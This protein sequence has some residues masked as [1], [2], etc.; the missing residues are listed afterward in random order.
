ML[1][2]KDFKWENCVTVYDTD[3][4]E[5]IALNCLDDDDATEVDFAT[6]LDDYMQ[7]LYDNYGDTLPKDIEDYVEKRIKELAHEV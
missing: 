2:E 4:L 7:S 3:L 5:L 6:A 1:E